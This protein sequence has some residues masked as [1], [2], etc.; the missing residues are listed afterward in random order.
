MSDRPVNGRRL[1]LHIFLSD[2]LS[3]TR[4]YKEARYTL[5]RSI[6]ERVVVLGLW[7]QGL[8]ERE[9][10][11]SGLEVVRIPTWIRT[12]R[13]TGLLRFA[14]LRKVV[15]ALSLLQFACLAIL[16]G[17]RLRPAVVSCHNVLLLP[18]CWVTAR[19]ASASLVYL[20]HELETQRSGLSG[21]AR[22][23]QEAI[24][25]AFIGRCEH[26]VVVCQPI[27]EWY[28]GRYG[29]AEVHVVRNV[30]EGDAIS[31]RTPPEGD[32]RARFG[33]PAAAKVFIYQGLFGAARGTDKL[34]DIFSRLSPQTA[35]LVLMGYGDEEDEARIR[36]LSRTHGNIHLQPAVPRDWIVSYTSG[37]DVGVFIVENPPLSYR[38]SLP[39]KFF[40]FA[41]A[42]LPILVSDNLE[43]QADLIR[44]AHIGWAVPYG[45]VE[46]RIGEIALADLDSA[47]RRTRDFAASAV[48][49]NDARAFHLVYDPARSRLPAPAADVAET[50]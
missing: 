37:A 19:L 9:T 6:F 47:R 45:D 50:P 39:N 26:V 12:A 49:E 35:H 44:G 2:I 10:K 18:V 34:L 3:E 42:G 43:L 16:R 41:H 15:A 1:N 28:V 29:L 27:A 48:W 38:W 36:A 46:R 40:E 20:P 23:V 5:D 32:F 11:E 33:I 21:V 24:E 25:R 30:P 7:S 14:P 22:K 13:R 4:L 8:H 31:V 17:A